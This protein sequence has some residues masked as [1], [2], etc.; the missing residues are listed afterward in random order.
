MQLENLRDLL[1]EHGIVVL[2]EAIQPRGST[3][4]DS[5]ANSAAQ[6]SVEQSSISARESLPS[7]SNYVLDRVA[8][9]FDS[10]TLGGNQASRGRLAESSRLEN[11]EVSEKKIIEQ[12]CCICLMRAKSFAETKQD[13]AKWTASNSSEPTN[14]S[15]VLNPDLSEM[16]M[17]AFLDVDDATIET[18]SERSARTARA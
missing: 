11:S 13:P 14:Y 12:P 1:H 9:K 2:A 4:N 3:D 5:D 10:L 18:S 17:E 15:P 7:S 8:R 6:T 16:N